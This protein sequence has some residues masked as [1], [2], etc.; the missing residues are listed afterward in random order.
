MFLLL[1]TRPD[2]QL[3]G[4]G[5]FCL[6][7][8]WITRGT[9]IYHRELVCGF[10]ILS[11][12]VSHC[13]CSPQGLV[14][15]ITSSDDAIS[16]QAT[17]LVGELLHMVPPSCVPFTDRIYIRTRDSFD[18]FLRVNRILPTQANIILPHSHSH[19]L[20]CLPTLMNMAASFDIAPGKRL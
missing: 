19:H 15:V 13:I 10:I 8:E 12:F 2:G 17:I 11:M 6:H 7:K 3:P 16:I 1:Q 4:S 14:E 9:I 5:A 20:H 18:Y